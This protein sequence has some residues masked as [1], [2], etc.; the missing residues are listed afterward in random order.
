MANKTLLSLVAAAT[1]SSVGYAATPHYL[2]HVPTTYSGEVDRITAKFMTYQAMV[3]K[4]PEKPARDFFNNGITIAADVHGQSV[5]FLFKNYREESSWKTP[6]QK[7]V[8]HY[9]QQGR[10][11][12]SHEEFE[13]VKND[14]I[15]TQRQASLLAYEGHS[16]TKDRILTA[17]EKQFKDD[18]VMKSE[19]KLVDQLNKEVAPGVTVKDALYL[20]DM[21]ITDFVPKKHIFGPI[22]ALGITYLNA[23]WVYYDHKARALDYMDSVPRVLKHECEHRNIKLQRLPFT[24][25]FDPEAW[26][27]F[28]IME[29]GNA[30]E[31]MRHPYYEDVRYLSK[32]LFGFDSQRAFDKAFFVTAGGI[33]TDK[34]QLEKYIKDTKN[35]TTVVQKVALEE[36][37]PEYY[38]H[39]SF[40][41]TVNDKLK[42][43]N[44]ALKLF[45]YM[46]YEPTLLGGAQPTRRWLEKNKAIIEEASQ[47]ALLRLGDRK[48]NAPLVVSTQDV[49]S[50]LKHAGINADG[51]DGQQLLELY[52]RLASL[53]YVRWR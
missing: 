36:F 2:K 6:E 50:E 42:D 30:L 11:E 43:K 39:F 52:D 24:E 29:Q 8:A 46:K 9:T 5:E 44:A 45:M 25:A 12:L 14:I 18:K 1:L 13:A 22:P 40:W 48:R 17:L 53:G 19:E 41:S 47:K 31:F 34:A 28:S 23:G 33:R 51:V 26:A 21:T 38:A 35:I 10:E 27:E 7:V 3:G 15:E 49:L 4:Y 20:P 32:V 16:K 37:I